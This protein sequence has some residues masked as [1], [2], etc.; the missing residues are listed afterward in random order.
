MIDRLNALVPPNMSSPYPG[1]PAVPSY[2]TPHFQ[3]YPP[4]PP[5]PTSY[6]TFNH[7]PLPHDIRTESDLAMFNQFMVTLG[8]DAAGPQMEHTASNSGSSSSGDDLFDNDAL[9]SLGLAGMPGIP[10]SA[11][12]GTAN[13]NFGSLYPSL[14]S[15]RTIA[16]LPRPTPP[17]AA[18]YAN[19]S[20]SMSAATPNAH[21]N[22]FYETLSTGNGTDDSYDFDTLARSR[23][24]ALPS[25]H[26]APKDYYKKAFRAVEPLGAARPRE[27]AERSVMPDDVAV[28][29]SPPLALKSLLND[30]QANPEFKLPAMSSSSTASH[31]PSI[32]A[33]LA[34]KRPTTAEN[35]VRQVKRLELDEDAHMADEKEKRR[36]HALWIRQ[37]IVAVNTAFREQRLQ[38]GANDSDESSST[39]TVG[40][41]RESTPAVAVA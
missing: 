13:V 35:L 4:P 24:H 31:L 38:Q 19:R 39:S 3:S 17:P 12:T 8:R 34:L 32:D 16:G 9:A 21:S 10:E 14:D 22:E 27:S 26:I 20:A 5:A 11:P 2:F 28:D 36:L 1:M 41:D 29:V 40:H 25:A 37:M 30:D 18:N 15:K 6:P 23:G 7:S 33:A